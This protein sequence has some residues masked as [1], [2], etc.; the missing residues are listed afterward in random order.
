MIVYILE[1]YQLRHMADTFM[2]DYA[3]FFSE[4]SARAAAYERGL[5]VAETD[6]D[7]DRLSS[8]GH[9]CA[10]NERWIER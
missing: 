9:W 5:P 2:S 10:I 7:M 1:E 8:R 3:I 4:D 6:L